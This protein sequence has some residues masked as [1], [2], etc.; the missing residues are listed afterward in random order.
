MFDGRNPEVSQA[1]S[2]WFYHVIYQIIYQNEL[3]LSCRINL[4]ILQAQSGIRCHGQPAA[5]KTY[6]IWGCTFAAAV[7]H[8]AEHASGAG[9][10]IR[11]FEL[12][13]VST[14]VK[15]ITA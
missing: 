6:L 11:P 13:S 2:V 7:T 5:R 15:K 14:D 12:D 3:D 10:E 8:H 1:S 4:L 9:A